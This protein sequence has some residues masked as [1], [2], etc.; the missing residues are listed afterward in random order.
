MAEFALYA[1]DTNSAPPHTTTKSD[2]DR[3]SGDLKMDPDA[4]DRGLISRRKP[5]R[6]KSDFRLTADPILHMARALSSRHRRTVAWWLPA[7]I[8]EARNIGGASW[9]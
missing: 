7:C 4:D 5:P 2:A 8:L 3:Q 9:L 1:I 6:F